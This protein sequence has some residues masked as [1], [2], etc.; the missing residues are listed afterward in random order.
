MSGHSHWAGI[1]HKKAAEDAKRGKTFSKLGKIISV[2][3]REK[4]GDPA[5]NPR[6]RIAIE[7]AQKANMPKDNIERAIK[8][9]MGELEGATLETILLEIYG[10]EGIAILVEGIT[11]NKNRTLSEIKKIL[12]GHQAKLASEGSVKWMFKP[13]GILTLKTP[14]TEAEKE[15]LE[16]AIIDAGAEDLEWNDDL[17]FV[18][19]LPEK[20]DLTKQALEAKSHQIESAALGWT[21]KN[22]VEIDETKRE[23]LE[24][25][26]EAL[27]EY[28]DVQEI[29]SNLK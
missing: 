26:F 8:K 15:K 2:T 6:L 5:M 3:V 1:K 4:G 21:P 23:K 14:S 13:T 19:T 10:P 29:Y 17:L 28:D 25:L 22:P 16:L 24:K 9:G 7:T 18:Y 27:D 11:D 20:L 12:H